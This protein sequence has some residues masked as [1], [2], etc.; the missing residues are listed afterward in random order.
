M[1]YRI[2]PMTEDKTTKEGKD[3]VQKVVWIL[4]LFPVRS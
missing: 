2:R 1:G 3:G 4:R